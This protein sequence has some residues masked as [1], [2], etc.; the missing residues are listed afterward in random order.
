MDGVCIYDFKTKE[1]IYSC[2]F[3]DNV[4]QELNKILKDY[5]TFTYIIHDLKL[6]CYYKNVISNATKNF[7]DLEKNDYRCQ[8]VYADVLPSCDVA[9]YKI[10]YDNPEVILN[11]INE[12]GF[13]KD[14]IINVTDF[15]DSKLITILP[16]NSRRVDTIRQL[17]YYDKNDFVVAFMNSEVDLQ[18][19]E[20]ADFKICFENSP[21]E[22]KDICD[23]TVKSNNFN[24][25][26]RLF[27]RIYTSYN[28]EKKLKR[29][30]SRK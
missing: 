2:D 6:C 3:V 20:I 27:G 29:L 4:K 14:L 7:Y 15:S 10:I 1:Y 22:I 23:F 8:F 5:E 16:K 18:L 9:M 13:A 24:D 21:K 28:Y 25:V 19:L 17:P 12:L 30:R 26:L 11:K